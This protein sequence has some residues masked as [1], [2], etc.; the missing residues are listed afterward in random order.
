MAS[1]AKR[2]GCPHIEKYAKR[3]KVNATRNLLASLKLPTAAPPITWIEVPTTKSEATSLPIIC[4]ID[5]LEA[6]YKHDQPRFNKAIKGDDGE[7]ERFWR[8]MRGKAV[9]EKIKT[10]IDTKRTLAGKMHGDGA[11]TT[12]AFSLRT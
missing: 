1:A 5:Q 6:I 8:S 10:E 2:Q 4:P 9:Y 12:R 3:S 11:P 7:V